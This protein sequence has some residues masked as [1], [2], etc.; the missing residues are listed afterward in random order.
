MVALSRP[1]R[2]LTDLS[3]ASLGYPR[4]TLKTRIDIA[5]LVAPRA[6]PPPGARR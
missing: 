4:A 1:R 3:H 6:A 2:I 5:A